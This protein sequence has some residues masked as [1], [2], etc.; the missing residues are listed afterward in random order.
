MLSAS[1][2]KTLPSFLQPVFLK[3]SVHVNWI[4]TFITQHLCYVENS[5]RLEFSFK[6]WNI[7][8]EYR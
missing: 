3:Y 5:S 4:V 1:L 6:I 2:N 7:H 8:Q